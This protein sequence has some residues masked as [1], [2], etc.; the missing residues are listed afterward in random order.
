MS[1]LKSSH[2]SSGIA[3]LVI[4]WRVGLNDKSTIDTYGSALSLYVIVCP[5]HITAQQRLL[6]AIAR[7]DVRRRQT[8]T[9]SHVTYADL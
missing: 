5:S 3:R 4:Q 6:S 1:L 8:V 2:I 7:T 9:S